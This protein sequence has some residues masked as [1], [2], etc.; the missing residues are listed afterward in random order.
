MSRM[1]Q[2]A[3]DVRRSLVADVA[4]ELRTPITIIR[5]K[6]DLA[7]QSGQPMDQ[8]SLLSLQD[9]LIRLT[10]LVDASAL[11]LHGT[12]FYFKKRMPRVGTWITFEA[13]AFIERDC[14]LTG[15]PLQPFDVP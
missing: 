14:L 5:G 15:L 1:I 6:L 10:R 3:E 12:E 7:Q 11:L 8:E 13:Q 9:E 2:N 4:H